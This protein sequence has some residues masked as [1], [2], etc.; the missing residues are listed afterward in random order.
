MPNNKRK[1][2]EKI[3]LENYDS[4]YASKL[5]KYK[6][7]EF[8]VTK[9]G[10]TKAKL[11]G[12]T[13]FNSEAQIYKPINIGPTLTASGAN[14]RIKFLMPES[15]KI[16]FINANEA[17]LYMGFEQKDYENV[18]KSNLIT[19]NKM[20]FTCGNSISVETLEALFSYIFDLVK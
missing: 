20:I 1:K 13:N 9:S 19:K 3:I 6:H 10:I 5:E 4:E 2:L 15:K 12:Y 7:T 14:S 16:K 11:I 18:L 17:Y 8:V